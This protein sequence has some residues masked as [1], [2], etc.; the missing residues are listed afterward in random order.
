[1][2]ARGEWE[3]RDVRDE[4]PGCLNHLVAATHR[5]EKWPRP[6]RRAP[7]TSITP[8]RRRSSDTACVLG[9]PTTRRKLAR[10]DAEFR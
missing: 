2:V 1:M 10:L 7:A 9:G 4:M 5:G 6:K 3:G 8:R